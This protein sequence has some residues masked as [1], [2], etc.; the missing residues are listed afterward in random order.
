MNN[1][2]SFQSIQNYLQQHVDERSREMQ[3]MEDYAS[4]RKFPI[5]GPVAGSYC[6]QIARMI[7]ATNVFELGSG[8]GYSTAWFARAVKENGGGTVHHVVW[9]TDLSNK[10]KIHLERLGY[11][12]IVKYHVGEAIDTLENNRGPYD[13]IFNDIEK[14]S[15]P[16]SFQVIE[17][18]IKLGGVLIVDNMFL[19]GRII[20]D[21]VQDASVEGVR[22][23]LKLIHNS[24]KWIYSIVPIRDGLLVAYRICS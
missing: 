5:I 2:L 10:A 9:D 24:D 19:N 17:Q 22:E 13:L 18:C 7:R 20:N 11:K 23:M 8:Y 21:G 12:D 16:L 14:D 6:Y 4:K 1:K 15:Y 3:I